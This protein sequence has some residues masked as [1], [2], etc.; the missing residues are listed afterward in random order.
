MTLEVCFLLVGTGH[1]QKIQ[2]TPRLPCGKASLFDLFCHLEEALPNAAGTFA[3]D[4]LTQRRI[5]SAYVVMV[6]G[7][8]VSDL[9]E[10]RLSDGSQVLM[11]PL[12]EGG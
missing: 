1:R 5:P 10:A 9:D 11:V 3:K 2:L 8:V 6:D 7:R 4:I 12:L